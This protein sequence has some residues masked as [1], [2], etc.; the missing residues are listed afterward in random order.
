MFFKRKYS[1]DDPLFHWTPRDPYRVRDLLNG[2]C[3]ILGRAGSAKTSSSG[4]TL[5]QAIVNNPHSGGL[6]LGAKPEDAGDVRKIFRN[7]RRKDLI[8]FDENARWRFNFL[9]D[10]G[11]GDP[12]NAVQC[13]TMIG[14][15][16]TQAQ[17]HNDGKNAQ[18]YKSLQDRFLYNVITVLQCA[19]EPVSPERILEFLMT[20]PT[21]AQEEPTPCYYTSAMKRAWDRPKSKTGQRDFKLAANFFMKEYPFMDK[22]VR[23]NALALIMNTLHTFNSGLVREMVGSE[24]NC[25]P[26]DI[27]KGKWVLVNFPPSV[28]GAVGS[29]ICAGWKF[30]TEL[31]ILKRKAGPYD[32]FCVIWCDEAHAVAN[33]FD[34]VSYIPQCRSHKGSLV[35]LT[36]S[37]S[38]F[39]AA[40]QG[41][42]GRH[43]ADA[44]LS[45][46]ATVIAHACDPVSAKWLSSKLGHEIKHR[47]GGGYSPKV[48]ETVYDQLFG[49]SS[50]NWNFSEHL[51]PVLDESAFMVG[52]TG[53]PENGYKADAIVIRSGESFSNGKQF[54]RMTFR[55][56]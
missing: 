31:A 28:Y 8:V 9:D 4:R 18:F 56:R 35:F 22:E 14:E 40:M 36:Q 54:L 27:L 23:S 19:G 32:P 3:L 2:G 20:A 6:I 15:T 42:A 26:A 52:R 39:Y 50:Y 41:E 29:F 11:K 30:L 33:S 17:G 38:S 1:L 46:F 37:V 25:S 5:M 34:C 47:G 7:A 49:Q 48:E 16:L 51:E 24:T 43:Q 45:N 53:G 55:Q 44:L 13:L 21:S 12:R 10:V